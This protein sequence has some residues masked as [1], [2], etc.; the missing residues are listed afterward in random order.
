M[1]NYD[2][3][4]TESPD[5]EAGREAASLRRLMG[6]GLDPDRLREDRDESNE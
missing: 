1:T 6:R 4:K 2:D 3:W 5:D